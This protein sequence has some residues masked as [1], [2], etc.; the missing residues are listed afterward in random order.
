MS[1]GLAR[2]LCHALPWRVES[3]L[4]WNVVLL[5]QARWL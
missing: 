2:A 3:V 4:E 1:L 5:L